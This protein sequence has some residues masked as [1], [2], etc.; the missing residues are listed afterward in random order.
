VH[1]GDEHLIIARHYTVI[2][3]ENAQ[4]ALG[5]CNKIHRVHYNSEVPRRLSAKSDSVYW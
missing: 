1:A 5:P 3:C 2:M 4:T